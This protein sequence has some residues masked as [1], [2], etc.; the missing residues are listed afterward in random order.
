MEILQLGSAEPPSLTPGVSED[1]AVGLFKALDMSLGG[2][3]AGDPACL[4]SPVPPTLALLL[5]LGRD[6]ASSSACMSPGQPLQLCS[7]EGWGKLTWGPKSAR[8]CPELG[9][10]TLRPVHTP[11]PMPPWQVLCCP[12]TMHALLSVCYS[13][14]VPGPNLLLSDLENKPAQAA[15]VRHGI[16]SPKWS[17]T[18]CW[19]WGQLCTSLQS[20]PV[21]SLW[22]LV[23]T[24]VIDINPPPG[25]CKAMDPDR[26]VIS[27]LDITKP[28]CSSVSC[29]YQTIAF[30]HCISSSPSLSSAQTFHFSF[31][32]I[33]LHHLLVHYSCIHLT[34]KRLETLILCAEGNRPF[35]VS[36]MQGPNRVCT[37]GE[38]GCWC[39]SEFIIFLVCRTES[40]YVSSGETAQMFSETCFWEASEGKLFPRCPRP[41][42]KV[43]LSKP[44][45]SVS[46]SQTPHVSDLSSVVTSPSDPDRDRN[47]MYVFSNL[48]R[49]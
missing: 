10:S 16:N 35:Q 40:W 3:K 30:H 13:W 5:C 37:E 15:Q 9:T 14:W 4:P 25:C 33:S 22:P 45:L 41:W 12:N 32:P 38:G 1:A 23:V 39:F 44:W 42:K 49:L 18:A 27:S 34:P 2:S 26:A 46:S 8:G 43:I 29:S 24:W 47:E 31:S 20:T 11:A 19:G 17:F 21:I 28:S 7:G 6:R 36:F 48:M